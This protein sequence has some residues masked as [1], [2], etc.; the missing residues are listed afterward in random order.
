MA[1]Q[2]KGLLSQI[3]PLQTAHV[4]EDST[5]SDDCVSATLDLAALGEGNLSGA[6]LQRLAGH[7]HRCSPCRALF[8]SLV[9]DAETEPQPEKP[10]LMTGI[11]AIG[12]GRSSCIDCQDE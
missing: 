6:D 5:V 3:T 10:D 11:A 2:Q 9:R 7:L 8:A 1:S 4:A 12:G